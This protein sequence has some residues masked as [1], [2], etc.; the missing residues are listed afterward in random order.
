MSEPLCAV[1]MPKWG[2]EMQEGTV[3][4]WQVGTGQRVAKNDPLLEVET[5]KVV[6]IVE[7]PA[8]GVLHRVL[9]VK[10]EVLPVGALLAVIGVAEATEREIDRFIEDHRARR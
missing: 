4:D 6:N 9:V 3:A 8:S 1:L 7:A 10:G 5:D 2:L